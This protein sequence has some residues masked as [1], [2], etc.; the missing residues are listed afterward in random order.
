MKVYKL[1]KWLYVTVMLFA[2]VFIT[3]Q[4]SFAVD[5]LSAIAQAEEKSTDGEFGILEV[6]ASHSAT[7]SG[8]VDIK[9]EGDKNV[10]VFAALTSNKV[11]VSKEVL[12]ERPFLKPALSY[13][14]VS[15][16][17]KTAMKVKISWK[18]DNSSDVVY[19]TPTLSASKWYNAYYHPTSMS[20][21]AHSVKITVQKDGN[22]GDSDKME[23][24][25]NFFVN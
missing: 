20:L 1:E 4:V 6:R 21:G 15:F 7:R 8:L 2:L 16:R 19:V 23:D 12:V 17:V 9:G 22:G 11:V 13:L 18:V 24:S 5:E 3:S 14:Y 25:C 10:E